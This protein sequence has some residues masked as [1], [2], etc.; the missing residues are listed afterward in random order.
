MRLRILLGVTTLVALVSL[1]LL[2]A[3]AANQAST[4]HGFDPANLDRSCKPCDDFFKFATGG[5]NA[6]NPIPAAYP[7]W[8]N[9]NKLEEQNQE[10]LRE[11]VEEA[12][13]NNKATRGSNL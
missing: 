11:I 13:K 1:Q 7:R 10:R 12:A 9:F 3:F 2:V 4:V 6:R 8:G 5:W